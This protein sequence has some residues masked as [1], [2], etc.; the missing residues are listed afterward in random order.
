[1]RVLIIG[2]GARE[3][4]LCWAIRRSP[5]VSFL[6]C[7]L[8]NGGTAEIAAN[9][10]LDPMQ[11]DACAE[12]AVANQI[13][14][15]VVGP[16]DPLAG[17]IVDA[18]QARGS[19]CL[20]PT[21]AAARLESSKVWA[22]EFMMRHGIPTAPARVVTTATLEAAI[23]DLRAPEATFPVAVKADGLA[24]G[25]GVVIAQNAG[26]AEAAL[27]DMIEQQR[28]GQSGARVL[29]EDFLSG[30]EVSVFA[31]CDGA[32]YRILGSACDHKRAFDGDQGPNT[33]GMG[34]YTPADWVAPEM[35]ELIDRTIIAPTINGM[36]AEGVP[37]TGF[38]FAGLMITPNGPSVI[39]FNARLGDPET[40]VIL[41][42]LE[43]SL[44]DLCVAADEGK[45]DQQPPLAWRDGAA[46]GVVVAAQDYP[47]S[48]AKGLP[49]STRSP[50]DPDVLVFHAGTRLRSDGTLEAQGGRIFT[51]VGFGPD[52]AAA[53]D[54]AYANIDRITFA[55]ARYRSDI[56]ARG[57]IGNKA[58]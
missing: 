43:T 16:E 23:H 54:R 27:R 20:G 30:R 44:L 35:M 42:Q 12:W 10:A 6:A 32:H 5:D 46:C 55:G 9:V 26:E 29:V 14:L 7:L 34:A 40:Q 56:G 1:M 57:R 47:I 33:G 49:I 25:K 11:F 15:T 8:G 18:F 2:S 4:A 41:P 52:L 50:L 21:Q 31:I 53:R 24:A 48:S 3:H 45:L 51:I 36:A 19:R 39:E 38:L 13:D 28:F 17:G 22:K 58:H 37:F